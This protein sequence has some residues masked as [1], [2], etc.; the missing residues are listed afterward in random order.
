MG[1][2]SDYA[3]NK[4]NDALHRGQALDAP[5]TMYFT[6]LKC[7]KGA[8]ANST[9]YALND[10]LAITASDGKI[11]LYKVTT[12]GTTAASQGSLYPGAINEVITDG[13][14]VLTEQNSAL[15]SNSAA[16]VEPIGGSFARVAVVASLANWSGTQGAG[17]TVASSGAGGVSSN[18]VAI[19]FPTP[20]A[21][22]CAGL[23]RIWGWA[24]FD[25]PSG[26][27]L[28]EVA[29]LT[30]LHAVT[31]GTAAPSFAAAAATVT[32]GD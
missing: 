31:N 3:Q 1:L 12:A 28:W 20:T 21:N 29:P 2:L 24:M 13:T 19:T 23:E 22:W 27:N 17:T 30:A 15:Q 5:A 4:I 7:S 26:G 16:I 32:I 6:L 8:R 25:A 11:H 9:A 14:A 10:T 18:N